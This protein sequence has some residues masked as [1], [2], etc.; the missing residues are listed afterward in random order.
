[1]H[2]L[3]RDKDKGK[4]GHKSI[5][6]IVSAG[7]MTTAVLG[8]GERIPA[9]PVELERSISSASSSSSTTRGSVDNN[10]IHSSHSSSSQISHHHHL[11]FRLPSFLKKRHHSSSS[12]SSSTLQ[13]PSSEHL[14]KEQHTILMA[15]K[16]DIHIIWPH[17][18][19]SGNAYIA[20]TWAVPGHN[21]WD[22]LP[23][24]R[25]PDTDMFEINLDVKEVEDISEYLDEDGYLHHEL[26]E[27]H[28]AHD[29]SFLEH[30]ASIT[31]NPS[32]SDDTHLSKRKRLRR[33]FGRQRSSSDASSTDKSND[34]HVDLPYHHQ[35]KD[36]VIVP[37]TREYRYQFKFVIDDEWKCDPQ[38]PQVQ[39]SEGH[40]NHEITV[41]LFEQIQHDPST[42]THI[43]DSSI[44]DQHDVQQPVDTPLPST[45]L[46]SE[47]SSKEE[48]EKD[49]DQID[50]ELSR[51]GD[52]PQ[53]ALADETEQP[54]PASNIPQSA[55]LV[56]NQASEIIV[57]TADESLQ[58]SSEVSESN[59]TIFDERDELNDIKDHSRPNNTTNHSDADVQQGSTQ[60]TSDDSEH[61][62]APQQKES[63]PP[64]DNDNQESHATTTA[65]P[66][67]VAV[68]PNS[69]V[70]E[71]ASG[72]NENDDSNS[73]SVVE[74]VSSE[75]PTQPITENKTIS[76]PF[77]L[78]EAT[79][80]DNHAL[81]PNREI[82]EDRST[83]Q[84]SN[85]RAHKTP[86]EV[87]TDVSSTPTLSYS[88][89][90]S[91]PLTPSSINDKEENI[92]ST[93]EQRSFASS[94]PL[95]PKSETQEY[96][97]K[98]HTEMMA[99]KQNTPANGHAP[100]SPSTS[101]SNKEKQVSKVDETENTERRKELP[102][103]YPNL[104]WSI[105]KTTVVVSAAV[106]VIGLGLGRRRD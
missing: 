64:V 99:T 80:A 39:D 90:P 50:S 42:T 77:A 69:S 58:Q 70:D 32:T 27:N 17:P 96:K 18:V 98:P 9:T 103:Q 34:L 40:F 75:Q 13:I 6:N 26:L 29:H 24:T 44:Q 97:L 86:L 7:L 12:T 93:E 37:L 59:D 83:P 60:Q 45:T 68:A 66:V 81:T 56:S 5:T 15:P 35:S 49:I 104:L 25:I 102:E 22:K 47:V 79:D 2:I 57:D 54:Q 101:L 88:Q 94:I 105:C 51:T 95:T 106:V 85:N 84:R 74:Q 11:H 48:I 78:E 72:T 4:D 52:T 20:G 30:Q 55:P 43:H 91:P 92:Q 28:H 19:P 8:Q 38:R 21:P 10:S 61:N 3:H 76:K 36:G 67:L 62:D 71:L 33:L 1:M 73:P 65:E 46:S 16:N 87:V 31:S 100:L 82:T 53:I 23:M 41:D 89:V 63:T 14:P